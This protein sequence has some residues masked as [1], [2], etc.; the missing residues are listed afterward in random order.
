VRAVKT[1]PEGD[2]GV[3]SFRIEKKKVCVYI[4]MMY[5]LYIYIYIYIYIYNKNNKKRIMSH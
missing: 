4:L 5:I 1:K 2:E 3:V